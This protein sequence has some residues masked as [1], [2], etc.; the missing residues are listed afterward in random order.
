[1]ALS[2]RTVLGANFVGVLLAAE[3]LA[4]QPPVATFKSG[5]DLVRVTAVV[6]DHRGRFV[7]DLLARDFE[8]LDSGRPRTIT[9]FRP[10]TSGVSVALL[11]DVSGSMEGHLS[12]AR[13]AAAHLLSW[14]ESRDEAAVFT[15]DTRL[16]EVKPFTTGLKTLPDAMSTVVPFGATSLHD[17]I[18]QTAERV[19]TREG[20]RRAVIVFTDG[21]DNW[22]RMQPPEVSA[23]ASR[24][25][26]PVYIFGVV[27]S[28]DNPTAETAT[29]SAEH[30]ALAGPLA[31]L[32]AWTGGHTF[33][34]STPGQRSLSARQIVD[35]LRHQYLIAFESSGQPGWHSLVVRARNRELTVRARSGYIAGQSSPDVGVGG[36]RTCCG[37]S[38]SPFR[39]RFSPL[40][41]QPPVPPRNLSEPA[42]VR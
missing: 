36:D 41:G 19:G 24:I 37:N 5:V 6:R 31:D 30:S 16:D 17:A 34:A 10:G 4:Q 7:R 23:I 29:A 9:D 32:A 35:E 39:S 26:V 28:I 11:F 25:D 2:G 42:L 1:V 13:E 40:A 22:S 38:S 8:I 15:F 33:V 20:R 12:N 18:A 21:H 27:P 14:L 3:L